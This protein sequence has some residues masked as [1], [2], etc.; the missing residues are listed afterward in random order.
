MIAIAVNDAWVVALLAGIPTVV[1]SLV[2]VFFQQRN[3]RKTLAAQDQA[4]LAVAEARE[5]ASGTDQTRILVEGWK[6]MVGAQQAVIEAH[7]RRILFLEEALTAAHEANLECERARMRLESRLVAIE[8]PDR[9]PSKSVVS[10]MS[11]Q[12]GVESRDPD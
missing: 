6:A 2:V 12:M 10:E 7:E 9:V 11:R 8:A 3:T 4:D 5:A 1:G